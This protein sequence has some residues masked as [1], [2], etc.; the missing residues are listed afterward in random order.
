MP[1]EINEMVVKIE[2][3]ETSNL[4]KSTSLDIKKVKEQLIEECTR[5]ILDKLTEH[6]ER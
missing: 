5:V 1:L 2:V 6:K 4:Q 3:L